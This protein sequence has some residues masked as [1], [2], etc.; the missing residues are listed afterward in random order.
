MAEV[1]VAKAS[2]EELREACRNTL[3]SR[4]AEINQLQKWSESWY[5]TT[6]TEHSD[7]RKDPKMKKLAAAKKANFDSVFAAQAIAQQE[8]VLSTLAG[9]EDSASHRDLKEFC[10]Q[11]RK[12]RTE[13]KQT[14]ETWLS[15]WSRSPGRDAVRK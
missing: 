6:T 3:N 10:R 9:C 13:Q 1:C 12:N 5:S 15:D 8:L 7:I 4:T 2:R 14:F 11:T